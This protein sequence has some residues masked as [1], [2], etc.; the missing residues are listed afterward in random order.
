LVVSRFFRFFA[1]EMKQTETILTITG[2]DGTGGSGVQADIRTISAMGAQA[3]SAVTCITVQNSL[4]IQEFFELPVDVVKGQIEAVVNDVQPQIIK[5][6]MLRSV[7]LVDAVVDMLLKYRPRYVIYDPIVLSSRGDELMSADVVSAV[8]EKLVPLCSYVV[9]RE[10]QA[11]HGH[12]NLFTSAISVGLSKGEELADAVKSAGDYVRS[13]PKPE[14]NGAGRSGELYAAFMENVERFFRCYSDVAFYSEQLNVSTRYL[15]QVTRRIA[16]R[17]P[18]SIIE[19]RIVE[20][21]ARELIVT[22]KSLKVIAA[23]LGFSSQAHL[24]RFFRKQK[25]MSPSEY[26]K[27]K[28]VTI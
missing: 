26:R 7:H 14:S 21:L 17:S 16:H 23:E 12:G 28:Q 6:G 22:N 3:V 19:E 2:S 4:G 27:R 18:K 20:E 9:E 5:V 1:A 8:K 24:T 11:A 13:L 10:K 25:G 15:A